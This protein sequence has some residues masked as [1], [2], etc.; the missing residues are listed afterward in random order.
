[1]D[2]GAP[3]R[4]VDPARAVLPAGSSMTGVVPAAEGPRGSA[5]KRKPALLGRIRRPRDVVLA[6]A[7]RKRWDMAMMERSFEGSVRFGA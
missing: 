6:C 5:R 7:L 1:M 4:S 2:L 3:L